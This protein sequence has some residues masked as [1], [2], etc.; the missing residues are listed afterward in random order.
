[1]KERYLQFQLKWH[2]YC[3]Y[4]LASTN[5]ELT[6]LGLHPADPLADYVV[7]VRGE[8]KKV[9]SSYSMKHDVAKTFL[10]SFSSSVYNEFLRQCQIAI[11]PPTPIPATFTVNE[12]TDD[13]Y[14]RFGGGAIADMFK[15]R[16]E[17]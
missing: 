1:M 17:K 10:I 3:S 14:Y 2:N 9:C 11:T 16:Y 4:F 13:V 5:R 8:W 6:D 7:A 15:T 12:D